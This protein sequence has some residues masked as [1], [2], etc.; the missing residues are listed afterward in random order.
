LAPIGFG[1]GGTNIIT[2]CTFALNSQGAIYSSSIPQKL[3][4]DHCRFYS[5]TWTTAIAVQSGIVFID[6]SVFS[7]SVITNCHS[8]GIKNVRFPF[9]WARSTIAASRI[10]GQ[11]VLALILQVR[12][13]TRPLQPTLMPLGMVAQVT[14]MPE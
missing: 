8:S 11:A 7:S 14:C 13:S 2:D 3:T 1:T 4:V 12:L 9:L 6:G 10:I 5:N